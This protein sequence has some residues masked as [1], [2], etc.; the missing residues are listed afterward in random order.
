MT[1]KD[2]KTERQRKIGRYRMTEKDRKT[3]YS[4]SG[5]SYSPRENF[6]SVLKTDE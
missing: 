5:F 3:N 2:G 6:P 1:E 4:Q